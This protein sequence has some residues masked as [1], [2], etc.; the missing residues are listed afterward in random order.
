[1]DL[2]NVD[3]SVYDRESMLPSVR[4]TASSLRFASDP[5]DNFGAQLGC[6]LLTELD[7][8]EEMDEEQSVTYNADDSFKGKAG[9][10]LTD[11][12]VRYV[13]KALSS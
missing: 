2:R 12:S 6:S 8:D 7:L 1:M 5:V 3:N 4:S 9:R 13:T 11:R 10:D